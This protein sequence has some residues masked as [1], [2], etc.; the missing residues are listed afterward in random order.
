VRPDNEI[1]YVVASPPA[2]RP[3]WVASV[4]AVFLTLAG[5]LV[6]AG[7]AVVYCVG[8]LLAKWKPWAGAV[9]MAVG[10]AVFTGTGNLIDAVNGKQRTP[11][12]V[13]YA[14]QPAPVQPRPARLEPPRRPAAP[15]KA[16]QIARA[17]AAYVNADLVDE[18]NDPALLERRIGA[19]VGLDPK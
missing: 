5:I 7:A 16:L 15:S 18:D 17:K 9:T 2:R 12:A 8:W 14:V 13:A 19:I 6:L 11:P 1:I 4:C 3:G 10:R